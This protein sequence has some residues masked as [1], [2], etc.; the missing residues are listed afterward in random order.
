MSD[1]LLTSI[2]IGPLSLKNRIVSTPHAPAL[3]EDGLPKERYQR[4]HLEKAKGGIAMTMIGGSSC[5]SPDSPSVFGQ[6]DVSSDRIIPYFTEF[7][8]RIHQEDCRIVCQISHLGRRTTWNDGDWL[9]VIAPSRVREPAHRGFPKIMDHADIQRVIQDYVAAARRLRDSGFDGVEIL[10]NGHL[11]GQFLSPDTNLRDD[12]YGGNF[13]NRLRFIRELYEAVKAAIGNDIVIGARVE[14]DSKLAEGL[15]QDEALKALQVIEKDGFIDYFNLNVG[16]SDTDYMLA[17]HP[18]P[19]M[20]VGLAPFVQLAGLFKSHLNTPTIHAARISDLATARYAVQEG[21]MDLVGMTRAHIADPH[22]VNKLKEGRENEIRPCVGAGYCIDRIYNE[23]EMLCIHNVA[24]TREQHISHVTPPTEGVVKKVVVVGG[25]PAGM[26]AARVSALRGHDVT[27]ME[28]SSQLGGQVRL[29]VQSKVRKD[30]IG[31]INWLEDEIKRLNVNIV[32]EQFADTSS[33]T[34]LNPGLVIIATG[35][36]PDHDYV[37]GGDLSCSTW[38]VLS[39]N[40]LVS[41]QGEETVLL[42][43]DHGQHQAASTVVE[44]CQRGFNV[45]LVTPDRHAVH[46]MG[47]SNYPM[48][49]KAFHDHQVRVTTDLRLKTL[50]NEGNGIT[51]HFASDFGGHPYDVKA[52]H[53]IIEHG[54]LPN[55]ELYHELAPASHNNG[56]IDIAALIAGVEQPLLKEKSEG[57]SL[58]R[59]GDAV[60]SRNIHA[61]I[62]D[63]RRLCQTI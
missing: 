37:E 19:A 28:A 58:F 3:A 47:S 16:R 29:A 24:T 52:D 20:F 44:L 46:E 2:Q 51:A 62:L 53:V 25:G 7:A 59:V 45:H 49:I 21:M 41:P 26:E 50:S 56:I 27:L 40:A 38:D 63:A 60:A 35:G 5:V 23:G 48:Y 4:Y 15:Q 43:D 8:E 55:D 12:E 14:M 39:G 54:T 9:P 1:P 6:L 32:W 10:Q 36:V 57:Y 11:P 42:Y 34:A 61:A 22:I 31:I 17:S 13:E 30:L 18:V 33:I